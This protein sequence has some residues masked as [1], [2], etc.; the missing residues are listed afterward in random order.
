MTNYVMER[1]E[2]FH[3]RNPQVYEEFKLLA[4]QMIDTGRKRYGAWT[5]MNVIR[6]NA[7]LTTRGDVFKINNN[8]IALYARKL[9]AEDEK[10]E[11]FFEI[12]RLK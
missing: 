3:E 8:F 1:F 12:R 9:I 10:F 4:N 5:L 2:L 7:D 6:W 11:G